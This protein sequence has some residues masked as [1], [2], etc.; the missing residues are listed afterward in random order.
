MFVVSFIGVL[1]SLRDNLT[2]LKVVSGALRAK[3]LIIF[4]KNSALWDACV[5]SIN[6]CSPLFSV[7]TEH[8]MLSLCELSMFTVDIYPRDPIQGHSC[9]CMKE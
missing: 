4:Y 6:V 7:M 1:A 8:C 9:G 2:L 5:M 3:L